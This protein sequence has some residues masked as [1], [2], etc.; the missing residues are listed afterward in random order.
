MIVTRT[1]AHGSQ[2]C[3]AQC[4]EEADFERAAHGSVR[5]AAHGAHGPRN[6]YR[7]RRARSAHGARRLI[8]HTPYALRAHSGG[9]RAHANRVHA[10]ASLPA[11][12][13]P[14]CPDPVA[15]TLAGRCR[16]AIARRAAELL[17]EAERN[18]VI[19]ITDRAKAEAYFRGRAL[20][21]AMREPP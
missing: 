21:D 2:L 18:W 3:A 20:A 6:A 5:T 1:V 8:P 11:I 13:C 19:R 16:G 12:P 4:L 15:C 10:E 7:K 9:A 14:S 17:A